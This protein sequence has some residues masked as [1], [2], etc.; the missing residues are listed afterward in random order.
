M[1]AV[2]AASLPGTLSGG[3]TTAGVPGSVANQ[4]AHLPP[5][6]ALFAAFLGYNPMANLLPAG[7]LHALPAANQTNVLGHSF[8]PNLISPPFLQGLHAAFYIS[9]AMC[10]IAATASLLR[11]RRYIYSQTPPANEM[12]P[13]D[14][15]PIGQAEASVLESEP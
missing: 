10:V 6:S 7:V 1:I 13:V 2:L 9:A 11:G 14:H 8:F 12:T 4:I 15:L 5:T 3:L